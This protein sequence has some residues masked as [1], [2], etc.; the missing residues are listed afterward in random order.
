MIVAAL[1]K[2]VDAEFAAPMQG[3]YVGAIESEE[4]HDTYKSQTL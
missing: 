4:I 1:Q 2:T 3:K